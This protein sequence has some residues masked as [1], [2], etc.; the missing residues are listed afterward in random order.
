MINDASKIDAIESL[1][2]PEPQQDTIAADQTPHP[3]SESH[4][5]RNQILIGPGKEI[6]LQD[7]DQWSVFME[8]LRYTVPG[9]PAPGFDIQGQ[10]CL[11]FSPERVNRMD[12]AQDVSM[13]PL[14]FQHRPISEYLDRYDGITPELNVNME[15][16]DAVDVTT[17]YLGHE[18]LKITDTFRP[19]QAFPIY[20]NCHTWGQF[21]GGGMLDILLDTGASKSYMS[22]GFY[23]RHPHLH[24]YPK[25][26]STVKNLQVGN[27]ELVATLFVIPFV[28]KIGKYLFEVYTLVSEIQQNM[29]V[30]L[31]V[32]NMFEVE[33]EISCWTSQFKFLNRSL[34]IF[35]LSTHRIK[36][37]AKAYV[38]AKVP[39]IEKL[40]GHAIAKL[41]YKGSLE[42]MK[43]RLV[44]NLTVIQIINNTP[45]MMYLS[46]QESMGIVDLRSLGYYNIKPQVMH[47]NLTGVHNL[48]PKWNLDFRFEEHFAKVSTQNVRYQKREVVRKPPDPYPWLDEDDP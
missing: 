19:E 20:S 16:D 47:F 43:I 29:D 22:K 18:S 25:F 13:A 46:T 45:S 41:L 35:T 33:G 3:I 32:K 12:Q 11:D 28:F 7:M 9:T 1:P 31:G 44:D 10:G 42:T 4:A 39:F 34:P 24:K 2:D 36:V 8:N 23:M 21:I 48:F 37:G 14:E 6:N 15:Y 30:I 26:N 27:G 38:K 5:K 40:S 17:T